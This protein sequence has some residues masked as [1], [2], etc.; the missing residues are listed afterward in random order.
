MIDI[1]QQKSNGLFE[2]SIVEIVIAFFTAGTDSRPIHAS[3][4]LPSTFNQTSHVPSQM[5]SSWLVS[6]QKPLDF[7]VLESSDL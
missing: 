3:S 7:T 5:Q 1:K 6:V 2:G 4:K